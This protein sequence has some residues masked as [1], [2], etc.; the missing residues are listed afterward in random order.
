MPISTKP[1]LPVKPSALYRANTRFQKTRFGGINRNIFPR[2][3]AEA[4][5][6]VDV[7]YGDNLLDYLGTLRKEAHEIKNKAE[8]KGNFTAALGGIRELV[9]IVELLAKMRGELQEAPSVNLFVSA[10]WTNI[11]AIIV[12]ALAPYPEARQ[13]VVQALEDHR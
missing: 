7:A 5:K 12:K 11:Q 9:R 6:A 3:M 10:E 4:Q 13:A 2:A 8:K 1:W